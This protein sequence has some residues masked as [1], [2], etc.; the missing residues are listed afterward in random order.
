[1]AGQCVRKGLKNKKIRY[2]K[3]DTSL[4]YIRK[5]KRCNIVKSYHDN[6]RPFLF[7]N[8]YIIDGKISD[9]LQG[10]LYQG[11]QIKTNRKVVIKMTNIKL[12]QHHI[13]LIKE[14]ITLKVHENVLKEAKLMIYLQN[15]KPPHGIYIYG[16]FLCIE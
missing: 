6:I 11:R 9:T 14:G 4:V 2:I 3:S 15:K 8:G 16:L 7:K 12:H 13:A 1:M 10:K 5:Q